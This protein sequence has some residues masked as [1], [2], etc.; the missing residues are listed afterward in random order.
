MPTYIA[1]RYKQSEKEYFVEF[2]TKMGI[3]YTVVFRDSSEYLVNKETHPIFEV[4]FHSSDNSK[5]H[6]KD[7]SVMKTIEQE[8][9]WFCN[10][11][12]A[13]IV[14]ICDDKDYPACCRH[15]LFSRVIKDS[16][17]D[18][19]TIFDIT[20]KYEDSDSAEFIFVF[21]EP[22]IKYKI[23]ILLNSLDELIPNV[24][25]SKSIESRMIK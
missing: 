19:Y 20:A 9:D 5:P 24:G 18:G 1:E 12:N 2:T 14:C 25:G 7:S 23:P 15:R 6:K 13:V 11:T 21:I 22:S 16:D 3:V 10:L 4:V 8:I 17:V